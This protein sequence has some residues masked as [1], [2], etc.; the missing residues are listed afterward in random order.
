MST[1]EVNAGVNTVMDLHPIQG[2]VKILLAASCGR[3]RDEL[4]S[5]GPLGSYPLLILRYHD[6][7]FQYSNVFVPTPEVNQFTHDKK[8]QEECFQ[9][10]GKKIWDILRPKR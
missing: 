6:L 4:W 10:V 2:Q 8:L 5:D 1:S 7:L 9:N 3:K